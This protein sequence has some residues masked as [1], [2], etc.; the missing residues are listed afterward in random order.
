MDRLIAMQT[1]V[2]VVET[3]SFT[4]AARR[5][6]I[7][8][9]AVSKAVAQLES[10]M[11]VRLL[12]RST[13]GLMPTE[14]GAA[15]YEGAR[16]AVQE[17]DLAELAAR[18]VGAGFTGRLRVCAAGTF[19]SLH[20]LPYMG[21]FMR[22]HP[23]LKVEFVLDDR[24]IDLVE[25][26]IDV[27]LRMGRLCD[28]SATAKKIGQARRLLVATPRYLDAFG[29]PWGPDEVAS[30]RSIVYSQPGGGDVW[31]VRQRGV[32]AS[33]V[34]SGPLYSTAAQGVR[35]AVLA[36]M[37][38]AVGSEWM[39]AP[40]LESGEVRQVLQDWELPGIDLWAVFPTGRLANA[41]TRAFIEY[42]SHLLEPRS[43]C[44]ETRSYEFAS[45]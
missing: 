42:A 45:A 4:A 14:A 34:L 15:F 18:G 23:D 8:Q 12:L 9:P 3:G 36:H 41:R 43:H 16:R 19:A 39:F 1:F 44:R 30:H 25:E 38:L 35:A 24:H 17:A 10:Q 11:S 6:K 28:S 29:C 26:G 5:L 40:E 20:V 7:G 13:R 22:Q 33:I 2:C 32:E 27:A 37:G 21:P 31:T